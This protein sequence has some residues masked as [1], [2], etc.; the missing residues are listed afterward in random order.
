MKHTGSGIIIIH[1][2]YNFQVIFKKSKF[3]KKDFNKS[4][5]DTSIKSLFFV[6]VLLMYH[7]KL[8][9]E[10]LLIILFSLQKIFALQLKICLNYET[11]VKV[12]P[13]N[14]DKRIKLL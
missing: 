8:L 1:I 4:R 13:N 3:N 10:L 2:S 6:E 9:C 12:K 7:C 5:I 11:N 14:K